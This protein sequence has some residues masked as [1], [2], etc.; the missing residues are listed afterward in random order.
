V[1]LDRWARPFLEPAREGVSIL[2]LYEVAEQLDSFPDDQ[3]IYA[4]GHYEGWGPDTFAT[5]RVAPDDG[6]I[7]HVFDGIEMCYVLEINLAKE[8]VEAYQVH[9]GVSA[10]S[11]EQKLRAIIYY[12]ENDAY[13]LPDEG[14]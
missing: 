3:T 14:K 7:R 1:A 2:T 12:A 5:V 13:L 6:R 8:I 4:V 9:H 10:L 11:T